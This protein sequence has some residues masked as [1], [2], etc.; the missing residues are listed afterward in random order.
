MLWRL[1]VSPSGTCASY[2]CYYVEE[3]QIE[4]SSHRRTNSDGELEIHGSLDLEGFTTYFDETLIDVMRFG[5]VSVKDPGYLCCHFGFTRRTRPPKPPPPLPKL[6]SRMPETIP[7]HI[8][9]GDFDFRPDYSSSKQPFWAEAALLP[10]EM[11]PQEIEAHFHHFVPYSI[12]DPRVVLLVCYAAF[13][14]DEILWERLSAS[15]PS[16]EEAQAFLEK[17]GIVCPRFTKTI[18]GRSI[19]EIKGVRNRFVC[20]VLMAHCPEIK[21]LLEATA[22]ALPE[23]TP[24]KI[25]VAGVF[26]IPHRDRILAALRNQKAARLVREPKNEYDANAIRVEIKVKHDYC[27]LG[28]IPKEVAAEWASVIDSGKYL[29]AIIAECREYSDKVYLNL[30]CRNEEN[31]VDEVSAIWGTLGGE[32]HE[33][34]VN[35]A[36]QSVI[37]RKKPSFYAQPTT[38]LHMHFVPM[39]W[40][41]IAPAAL[42][43]CS[44]NEW[45]PAYRKA[46]N[47][48]KEHLW[49]VTARYGDDVYSSCGCDQTPIE[50]ATWMEF[51]DTCISLQDRT[52]NDAFKNQLIR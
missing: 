46:N 36:K 21:E 1:V 2:E 45:K 7:L 4:L 18:K 52:E 49:K 35:V 12:T 3:A 29:H 15:I 38:E 22:A 27:K 25:K 51:I 41:A 19:E 24:E 32:W 6:T 30:I 40:S 8:L 16:Y 42:R 47:L 11:S 33:A 37:Y 20:D 9:E 43:K 14:N 17:Y 13:A 31:D 26:A 5:A 44:F 39:I 28:Y 34:K 10:R 50:W 48:Y 23:M